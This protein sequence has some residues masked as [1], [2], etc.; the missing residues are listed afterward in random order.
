MTRPAISI[1]N[2]SKKY[3]LGANSADSLRERLT[4]LFRL[5]RGSH[6]PEEIWALKDINLEVQPGEV[7]GIIG[8]NGAGKSTLLKILSRITH[9]TTGRI[10][11]NGRVSSLL[12]VGTGFHPELTGRENIY[13][14]AAILGMKRAE[15]KK[16]FDEIVAFAEVEKF[17]DTPVK[18]YS[19][20]MYTRL[21]FSVAAH[22][23][24]EILIVDEVLSV[25]DAAFQKKSLGK[26]DEVSKQGRTILFVSHNMGS[27]NSLTSSCILLE[28][29]VVVLS[30]N[31][32]QVT[33]Y[34]IN[35]SKVVNPNNIIV[36]ENVEQAQGKNVQIKTIKLLV[37]KQ[38]AEGELPVNKPIG[39]EIE[40]LNITNGSYL[41]PSINLRDHFGNVIFVSSNRHS[42]N[43]L[44]DSWFDRAMPIGL[45]KTLCEIPPFLLNTKTYY[46]DVGIANNRN[47]WEVLLEN[48]LQL[49]VYETGEM[50]KDYSVG[51]PGQIRP[52]LKWITEKLE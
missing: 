42:T 32:S 38:P 26:M 15:I 52:Y 41:I 12:E 13:M 2:L 40:Y 34:Y 44:S 49:K 4:Q 33:E 48:V 3:I 51:V 1:Q 22:L 45:Y 35:Q 37:D 25:G 29:G 10:E 39:I 30:G 23:D 31:T 21:A 8:H 46:V 36:F 17:I 24:P 11:I 47:E 14:N 5:G 7:L 9:P 50:I 20:G 6:Q 28:Q 27:V 43:E 19:S 18:R 16:K